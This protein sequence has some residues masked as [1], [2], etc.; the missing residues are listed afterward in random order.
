MTLTFQGH[1]TNRLATSHFLLVVHCLNIWL[2]LR[3]LHLNISASRPWPIRVTTSH[4]EIVA[5]SNKKLKVVV[6]CVIVTVWDNYLRRVRS[7]CWEVLAEC[8]EG[9]GCT[10]GGSE[11]DWHGGSE[12]DCRGGNAAAWWELQGLGSFWAAY[13]KCSATDGTFGASI[14]SVDNLRLFRTGAS[15]ESTWWHTNT[16]THHVQ[17]VVKSA[18][19]I[20]V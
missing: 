20:F 9:R 12:V 18:Q 16:R 5:Q 7:E 19:T 10:D 1:V 6:V 3:Y 13:V 8:V 15:S 2:F 4:S 17:G 11:T 14:F